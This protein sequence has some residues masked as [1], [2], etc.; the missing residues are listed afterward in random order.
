ML[1]PLTRHESSHT[2]DLTSGDGNDFETPVSSPDAAGYI[3]KRKKN[4]FP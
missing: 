3:G 2:D 4:S 1:N